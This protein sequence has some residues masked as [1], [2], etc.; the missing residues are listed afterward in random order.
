MRTMPQKNA[1]TNFLIE[2][3]VLTQRDAV[4]KL[5]ENTSYYSSETALYMVFSRVLNGTA[6]YDKELIGAFNK[7][8]DITNAEELF[9]QIKPDR[10]LNQEELGNS[11]FTE[12]IL[13]GL[14]ALQSE[15]KDR[16][17]RERAISFIKSFR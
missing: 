7:S 8:F 15:L 11:P 14:T 10:K 9:R 12:E 13:Q 6:S 2:R 5:L 1:V 3:G 16:F 4:K 17:T